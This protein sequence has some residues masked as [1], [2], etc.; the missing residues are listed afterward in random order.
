M[1]RVADREIFHGFPWKM[2]ALISGL[3][4]GFARLGPL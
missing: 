1:G 4:F 3:A 2:K